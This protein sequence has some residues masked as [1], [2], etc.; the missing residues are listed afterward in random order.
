[1][2]S[3]FASNEEYQD[4][5]RPKHMYGPVLQQNHIVSVIGLML[6]MCHERR[7]QM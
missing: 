1:M 5:D 6:D 4:L 7:L 2:G 3:R